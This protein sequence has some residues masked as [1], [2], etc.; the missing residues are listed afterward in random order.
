MPDRPEAL[1]RRQRLWLAAAITVAAALRF[2]GME[3]L[4]ITHFDEGSYISSAMTV[5]TEGVYSFPFGQPLQ[6][7]PLLPWMIGAVIWLTQAQWPILGAL[8]SA[9]LGTASV[10][11][12]FSV[13]R[14]WEGNHFGLWGATLLAVS[15]FHV[16]YS[17]MVLTDVPLTFWFLV[18]MYFVTRLGE[19]T[20]TVVSGETASPKKEPL[21][22]APPVAASSARQSALEI[23][24]WG[25]AAGLS[26]GAAWNTKYNGWLVLAIAAFAAG[27][28]LARRWLAELWPV[29]SVSH[30]RINSGRL[31]LGLI[32]AASIAAASF[33]PWYLYVEHHFPG[34]YAAVTANHR[35]YFYSPVSWTHHAQSL[36]ASLAALRHYGWI[37][38]L[39]IVVVLGTRLVAT[40]K[41]PSRGDSRSY[42]ELALKLLFTL[43]LFGVVL[44]QGGDAV[45]ILLGTVGIVAALLS[46]SWPR[47]LAAVW[48]GTFVVLTPLYHPY[49]RLMLPVLPAC[50][51]LLLWLL[52]DAW[53]GL[54]RGNKIEPKPADTKA[55]PNRRTLAGISCATAGILGL[56]WLFGLHPYG[57]ATPNHGIWNRWTAEHSYRAAGQAIQE[58]TTA[59]A[60]IICQTQ[61]AMISYCPR[62][63]LVAEDHSFVSLL[64]GVPKDRDCYLLADFSWIH[65]QPD[66]AALKG[67]LDN[68]DSLSV[69]AVIPN[70]LSIVTLLDMLTPSETA[71]KVAGNLP[72]YEIGPAPSL[73]LPPPLSAPFE[74]VIVLYRVKLPRT[75]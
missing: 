58:H 40:L 53:P 27:L 47:L 26:A 70:D 12:F 74:D 52:E 25:L 46:P 17:R 73:P 75:D 67:I 32:V 13:A 28:W 66:S 35:R 45:L 22:K 72:R 68:V 38:T 41:P 51:C 21:K 71:A 1:N 30:A 19:R 7:P 33:A 10:P 14:R 65:G 36:I 6:S 15:D 62:L 69:V 9:A 44:V 56:V 18:T 63:P 55:Y 48:C 60:I 42:L 39:A 37:A 5:A 34:G 43:G 16:A 11:M 50:I 61:L 31:A 29:L 20:E 4:S 59:D 2:A 57:L 49:P 8:V 24:G 64:E 54:I 3:S 23:V